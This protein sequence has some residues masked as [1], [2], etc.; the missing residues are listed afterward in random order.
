MLRTRALLGSP[1]AAPGAVELAGQLQTWVALHPRDAGAWQLLA[2]V[3]QAQGQMLRAVRAEAEAHAARYDYAAAVD[4]FRAGQDLARQS[5]TA[6]DHVE[7]S[8]IDT[9]LRAVELLLREQ[10]AE[11]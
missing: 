5:R 2:S 11:R 7:A 4:R 3:W 8:I 9:R 1:A 10:T 6:A